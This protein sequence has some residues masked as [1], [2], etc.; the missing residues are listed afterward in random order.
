MGEVHFERESDRQAAY[1]EL[2]EAEHIYGIEW[3]DPEVDLPGILNEWINPRIGPDVTMVEV[4]SGGGRWTRFFHP[5]KLVYSVDGTKKSEELVRKAFAES[6]TNFLETRVTELEGIDPHESIHS[7]EEALAGVES[8]LSEGLRRRLCDN[9][10]FLVSRDGNLPEIPDSSVDYVFSYDTFVHFDR[11]LFDGY[12]REF[13]RILKP[14]GVLH[15]HYAQK[16]T[17]AQSE[18][19][20]YCDPAELFPFMYSLGFSAPKRRWFMAEGYGAVL[21]ELVLGSS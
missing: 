8:I 10:K 7:L 15:L 3:G 6:R 13:A 5:C 17:E 9:L 21:V 19:Y 20:L 14:G 16:L 1:L 11:E 4:G 12:L 18:D 2:H